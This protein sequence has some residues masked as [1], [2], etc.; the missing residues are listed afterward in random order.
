LIPSLLGAETVLKSVGLR[1]QLWFMTGRVEVAGSITV[2]EVGTKIA[3][4]YCTSASGPPSAGA[5]VTAER[6][7]AL[8]W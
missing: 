3:W 4:H 2:L 7:R 1:H 5:G 8:A 6:W